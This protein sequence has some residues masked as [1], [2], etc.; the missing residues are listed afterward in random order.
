MKHTA[1]RPAWILV[2]TAAALAGNVH[3]AASTSDSGS[4]PTATRAGKKAP[5]GQIKF[6]PGSAET[7]KERSARLKRECKGRVNAGACS[8]YTY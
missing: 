2:L 7:V 1:V 4:K 3:A 5:G 8:G 6:L